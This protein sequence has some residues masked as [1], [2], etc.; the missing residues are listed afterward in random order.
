M[1]VHLHV[2]RYT[3]IH[4]HMHAVPVNTTEANPMV[5][6]WVPGYKR[7]D[8]QLS[9]STTKH[10]VWE[11]YQKAAAVG[12]TRSVCYS[13][14]TSLWQQLLPHVVV[15]KPMSDLCWLCQQNS[16]VICRSANRPE[17]EKSLVHN[18][19]VAVTISQALAYIR[20]VMKE[21]ERK[22]ERERE[23]ETEEGTWECSVPVQHTRIQSEH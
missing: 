21:R 23:R 3:C 1:H 6:P 7:S 17:V 16:T 10:K 5:L 19:H 22:R 20:P 2:Y 4:T 18:I 13:M 12:S 9:S 11:L 15:M 8:I 14:F